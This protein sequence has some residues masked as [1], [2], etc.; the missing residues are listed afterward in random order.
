MIDRTARDR[1]AEL[2]RHFASGLIT[3]D[4]FEDALPLR[5]KDAAIYEIWA[6]GAWYLY[7]DLKEHRL[8]DEYNISRDKK[9]IV[10][11]WILFLKT[12]LEYE[13]PIRHGLQYLFWL[14]VHVFT[15]G[16]SWWIRRLQFRQSG[17]EK[18]WPFLKRTELDMALKKP[19]YM[20]ME[21][22]QSHSADADGPRR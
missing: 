14:P 22:E 18:V 19:P 13:W 15:L 11:R 7:D 1:T 3:N 21:S 5:S 8:V 16:I 12:D 17:D 4:E 9:S 6:L 20:K 2:L 10:A